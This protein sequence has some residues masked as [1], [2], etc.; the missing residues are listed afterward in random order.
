[1]T[2]G[3]GAL[4]VLAAGGAVGVASAAWGSLVERRRFGIRWETVPVL[5]AG[6]RDVTVLEIYN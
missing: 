1:M 2:R 6:S 3:R 5:P 4:G